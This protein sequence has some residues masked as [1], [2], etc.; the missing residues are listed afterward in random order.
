MVQGDC[1][2]RRTFPESLGAVV[3]VCVPDV[4]CGR[5]KKPYPLL[6]VPVFTIWPWKMRERAADAEVAGRTAEPENA[7]V[8]V[9]SRGSV[10]EKLPEATRA[11]FK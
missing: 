11:R 9:F 6:E 2:S 5:R 8:K 7:P 1:A 4:I 3:V 10:T